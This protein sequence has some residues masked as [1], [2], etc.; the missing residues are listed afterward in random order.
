L[1]FR[2][3]IFGVGFPAAL[4]RSATV[5]PARTTIFWLRE[6]TCSDGGTAKKKSG[7]RFQ[8][9]ADVIFTIFCDFRQF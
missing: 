1:R 2:H 9:G 7:K 5:V 6:S 8:P 3:V 4:Q